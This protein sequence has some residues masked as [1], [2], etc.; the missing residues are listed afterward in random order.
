VSMVEVPGE[1]EKVLFEGFELGLPPPQPAMTSIRGAT[2]AKNARTNPFFLYV[3]GGKRSL[4]RP[5]FEERTRRV[6]LCSA[7]E[8]EKCVSR[9]IVTTIPKVAVIVRA[10]RA[11]QT[12]GH[13]KRSVTKVVRQR[14][15]HR[16]K[17]RIDGKVAQID[18]VRM[19][20]V[21]IWDFLWLLL[22]S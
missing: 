3:P 15:A 6:S 10:R 13:A 16:G 12:H 20:A 8:Q 5:F 7:R 4:L 22:Y 19:Y 9:V 21:T 18:A 1:M 14:T 17:H 11:C 2:Q